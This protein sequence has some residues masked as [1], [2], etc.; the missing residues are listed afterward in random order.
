[1]GPD[2]VKKAFIWAHEIDPNAKLYICDY[3]FLGNEQDN[4]GKADLMYNLVIEL[5]NDNVPIGGVAEQCHIG[6]E[7][8]QDMNYYSQT[9]D[10]FGNLGLD[11]QI[12]ECTI[13]IKDGTGN[14]TERL[15][16]QA[17]LLTEILQICLTKSYF[18]GFS[19][20]GFVDS[21]TYLPEDEYPVL[22][23]KDYNPKLSYFAVYNAFKNN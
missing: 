16:K 7:Y 10:R 21:H 14:K 12:T 2:F 9:M 11:F 19:F 6:L 8:S 23:D 20:W 4:K 18:T 1:M 3:D 15:Q 13:Q 22:F 5:L 17:D